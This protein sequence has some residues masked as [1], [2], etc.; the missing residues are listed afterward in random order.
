[1][2]LESHFFRCCLA[3]QQRCSYRGRPA[4]KCVMSKMKRMYDCLTN[5]FIKN[6]KYKYQ[7]QMQTIIRGEQLSHM[8]ETICFKLVYMLGNHCYHAVFSEHSKCNLI[9]CQFFKTSL[10]PMTR[11]NF[12]SWINSLLLFLLSDPY[13]L[14]LNIFEC[15]CFRWVLKF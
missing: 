4:C 8:G 5:V 12:V 14:S 11:S 2:K 1:M 7:V 13:F 9:C 15:L 6:D 10:N 3:F